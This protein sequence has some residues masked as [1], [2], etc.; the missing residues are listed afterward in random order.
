MSSWKITALGPRPVIE[1]A[2]LAHEDA[3]DWDPD[4]VISGSESRQGRAGRVVRRRRTAL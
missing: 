3:F 2:L 1:G 4:I